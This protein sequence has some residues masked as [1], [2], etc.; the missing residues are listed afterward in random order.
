MNL[1]HKVRGLL[2]REKLE[3]EMGEEMRMHLEML[4]DRNRAA[5]MSE[6]EAR[7]AARRQ[8]G[9]AEQVKEICR[10]QRGWAWLEQALQDLRYAGRQFRRVPGFMGVAMLTLGIGIGATTAIFSIVNSV[11]IQPLD[12]AESDRLV[13]IREAYPP[14][15]VPGEIAWASYYR[16]A[17]E[18]SSFASV[19]AARSGVANLIG[20]G[21]PERVNLLK[22]TWNYFAAL[23]IQ[24]SLGRTFQ[25]DEGVAGNDKVI[26]LSQRL[27]R[28]KF[29]RDETV[30]GRTLRLN[31]DVFTIVGVLPAN[32]QLDTIAGVFIPV[33]D[34]AAEREN[35]SYQDAAN[36][37]ARLRDGVSFEQAVAEAET[38]GRAMEAAA[39]A[40]QK[41]LKVELVPLREDVVR[42]SNYGMFGADTLLVIL[43]GAV[44][45]LLLIACV[46]IANLLLVRAGARRKEFA[47]RIALGAS[48]GR[49]MRQLLCESVLLAL[50]GGALGT[51]I[52]YGSLALMKPLTGNLPRAGEISIDGYA[53]G[54][55]AAISVLTGLLFGVVPATQASGADP[56]EGLR[57]AHGTAEGRQRWRVR[58]AFVV[59]EVALALMLLTGAGLLLHSFVRLQR[60]ELGFEAEGIF[61]NRLE[62]SGKAYGEAEQRKAFATAV[63]ERLATLPNVVTAAFTS[64]MPIFGSLGTGVKV[65]RDAG[66]PNGRPQGAIYAAITPEYFSALGI[67]LRRGR[68]FSERDTAEAPRV[69]ILSAGLAEKCFPGEDPIGQR[70]SL[71]N[72]PD[73][74]REVVGV[75][76]DVKQWGPASSTVAPMRGYVY[77]PFAQNPTARNLMLVV[78][79]SGEATDLA[80]ALRSIIRTIDPNMPLTRMFRLSDGVDYS[81]ARFRFSTIVC[82]IFAGLALLLAII[83]IYGVVGYTVN[84][85][86]HEIGVR[87]ALGA[88]RA[89]VVRLMVRQVGVWVAIGVAGGVAGSLGA[90]RVLR[91]FLFEVEPHDPATIGV[92]AI[93]LAGVAM[94]A[95]WLPARRAARVDPMVALRCE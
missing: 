25:A 46:N 9:G 83:G 58:G 2:Q 91:A 31:D 28:N 61:A 33:A 50:L 53:L 92:V 64:G 30:I 73:A 6:E 7:F 63:S 48:R 71:T 34:T 26:V 78:R 12:F 36:V 14:D 37:I 49:I 79:A 35:R 75:V 11:L 87:M 89:S 95:C 55:A 72:G 40:N 60:V 65:E 15:Y 39:P 88:Q 82:V 85:R 27:W 16:W 23:G 29:G 45:F 68:N 56:I 90:G 32:E 18:A 24:P 52:A 41:G 59:A 47:M 3:A 1:R 77:E 94:L 57:R 51:A 42:R 62:L 44:G 4:E 54:F 76:S 19:A 38:I 81:I 43:L 69:V 67:S 74:W 66:D 10:E 22:V 13:V 20:E 5:G 93:V 8:F 21:D 70:V 86:T 17:E 84:R 80:A